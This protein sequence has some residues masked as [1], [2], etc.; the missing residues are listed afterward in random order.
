MIKGV[1]HGNTLGRVQCNQLLHKVDAL[2]TKV[3][4]HFIKILRLLN[5]I[6]WIWG[7]KIWSKA[8]PEHQAKRQGSEFRAARTVKRF[9]GSHLRRA[10]SVPRVRRKCSQQTTRQRLRRISSVPKGLPVIGTTESRFRG[11]A[12]GWGCW[13]LELSRSQRFLY[14]LGYL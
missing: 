13:R 12:C 1:F 10:L 7:R 3:L 14:S 11:S 9:G 4:K 2:V 5:E 6:L 8:A